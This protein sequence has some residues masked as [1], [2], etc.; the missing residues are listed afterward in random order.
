M[1]QLFNRILIFDGSYALHRSLSVPNNWDMI[2]SKGKRTGGIFGTLRTIQKE[3]KDYNFFPVVVF[4]GGLS[5]RRLDIY[6]NYKRNL[7]RQALLECKEEDK[8]EEQLLD[9]EFRREYST[10]RNDL[11]QLLPLFGIPCIRLDQWEGDDLIYIISKMTK[12]SIVV[13]DDKDLIQLIRA[14]PNAELR[15]CRIRRPLRDEFLDM[16]S[17][18]DKGLNIEEYIG[19]KSIVGDPSDNIPSA[20]FQVG[21]KTAPGLFE[22]YKKVTETNSIFPEN[23]DQLTK[24]CKQFNIQKRK[25]YLNFNETQ[26]L[27]NLLLTDLSLVD[28][29]INDDLLNNLYNSI[30]EQSCYNNIVDIANL[31]NDLEIRTF[32]YSAL[33]ERVE[34]LRKTLRIEDV[35]SANSLT[36]MYSNR[37]TLL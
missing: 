6:P 15:T 31:L 37:K 27:N 17:L 20:C 33:L 29:E 34:F 9:E 5:K 26:F 35:V 7:E 3:L 14:L 24:A 32:D 4:D 18:K 16:Q 12:N 30:L 8:T 23:E 25:A 13:S 22:L 21:E 1:N 2:N 10:Q 11:I 28:N 19:C 36:E